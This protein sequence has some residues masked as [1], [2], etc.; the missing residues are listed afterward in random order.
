M[1]SFGKPFAI[2][3]SKDVYKEKSTHQVKDDGLC[4]ALDILPLPMGI[5]MYLDDGTED[6]LRWAQFDGACHMLA[7]KMGIKIKT[8]FKWR[9]NLMDSLARPERDYIRY[10]VP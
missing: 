8:G 2:G 6:D 1:S 4:D 7:S 9:S 3:S 10:A 5:N